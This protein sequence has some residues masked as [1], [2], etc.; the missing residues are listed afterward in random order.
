LKN[1]LTAATKEASKIV[2]EKAEWGSIQKTC[3]K[4]SKTIRNGTVKS[5]KRPKSQHNENKM[6]KNLPFSPPKQLN[7]VIEARQYSG[8]SWKKLSG[9]MQKSTTW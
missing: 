8:M 1:F 7:Q 3:T 9:R 4:H 6:K 5:R 2:T